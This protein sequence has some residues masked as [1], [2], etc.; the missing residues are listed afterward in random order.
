MRALR[1]LRPLAPAALLLL[2]AC[3]RAGSVAVAPACLLPDEP[4][5]IT[6]G[7]YEVAPGATD[8]LR[9]FASSRPGAFDPLPDSCR[10]TWELSA[11]A[12]A[13]LGP[14]SGVL[15]VRPDARDAEQFTV[16]ARVANRVIST[17][18]RVVDPTASPLVGTWS[19]VGQ[20]RC[21]APNEPAPVEEPIREL[22]FRGD[23]RFSV[24]WL[25]FESYTDYAGT[26]TYTPASGRLRL[27]VE[28][29]NFLPDDLDL[30]GRA[31]IGEDGVLHLSDL[32]LGSR[33]PG[34]QRACL[35]TFR[36]Q[37]G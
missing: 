4:L 9:V 16:S 36:K 31:V 26:Y 24:T 20:A 2:G 32:W 29:S 11:D 8:T 19:Q 25:P 23:G 15:R 18:V 28:Q 10:P 22:R 12:P 7:E 27:H 3:L 13:S 1:V 5:L 35:L 6:L 17:P 34:A 14:Q 21:A 33:T 30:D 37:N